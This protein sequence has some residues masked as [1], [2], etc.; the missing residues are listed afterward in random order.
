M[1]TSHRFLALVLTDGVAAC[2]P[3]ARR[4]APSSGPAVIVFDNQSLYQAAV[5]AVPQSG[6]AFRIGTVP[7]GRTDTLTV[8]GAAM[9]AGGSVRLIADLLAISAS[10]RTGPLTLFPGDHLDVT[11]PPTANILTVLPGEP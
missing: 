9:P 4:Q 5:Y 2:M 7:G 8:D 1:Q 11:L 6:A 10:P 3:G